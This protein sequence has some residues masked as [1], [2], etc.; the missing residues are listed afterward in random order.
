MDGTQY[1]KI[2]VLK[3]IDIFLISIWYKHGRAFAYKFNVGWTVI[4]DMVVNTDGLNK[5]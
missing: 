3:K 1:T 5:T 4:A 2:E